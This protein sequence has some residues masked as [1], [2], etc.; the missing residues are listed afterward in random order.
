[1]GFHGLSAECWSSQAELEEED[2]EQCGAIYNAWAVAVLPE[3]LKEASVRTGTEIKVVKR[4]GLDAAATN[5]E[6]SLL[7][8]FAVCWFELVPMT[9]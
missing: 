3:A 9:S 1:M 5:P 2:G 7:H 8:V 4:G 6:T